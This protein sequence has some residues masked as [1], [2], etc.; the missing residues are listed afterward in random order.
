[1]P[2]SEPIPGMAP[3]PAP[4][5][6]P[7]V[8]ASIMVFI[9]SNCC[10]NWLTS[11]VLVPEPRAI[12]S[13]REPLRMLRSARS[14]GVIERAMASIR[15]I[16]RSSKLSISSRY[17]FMPGIMPS[18]FFI[19]PS[20]R[21]C[22]ICARKSSTVKVPVA[23]FWAAFWAS[24]SSKAFWAC[25]IRV[26]RSPISKMRE[27]IRSAW[28]RSKSSRPSPV[29][30]NNTGAPVTPRTDRAAPPRASPSSLESTTPVK[31]TPSRK[32]TEVLTAS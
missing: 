31:P 15:S 30:A 20:L 12:R 3:G 6:P 5:P 10:T 1:M 25:S 9:F 29:E 13:R 4:R 7:R 18:S 16:W 11:A 24:S 2:G 27:A 23:I 17:W 22:C 19:E 14:P 32:A 26:S 8:M 28:K 21:I